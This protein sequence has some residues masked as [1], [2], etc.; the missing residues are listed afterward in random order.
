MSYTYSCCFLIETATTVIYTDC[1]LPSLHVCLPISVVSIQCIAL[2]T[3]PCAVSGA[4]WLCVMVPQLP[5]ELPQPAVLASSTRTL[6]PASSS[7][8]ALASPITPPPTT[9]TSSR[10]LMSQV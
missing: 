5:C 1:H 4:A 7:A 3:W 2:A 6:L 9:S 8:K 10:S